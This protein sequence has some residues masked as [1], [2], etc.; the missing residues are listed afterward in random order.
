MDSRVN[1]LIVAKDAPKEENRQGKMKGDKERE[2]E[3]KRGAFAQV[4]EQLRK[5]IQFSRCAHS[6]QRPG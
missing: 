2:R 5:I 6:D 4:R 1:A 3:G